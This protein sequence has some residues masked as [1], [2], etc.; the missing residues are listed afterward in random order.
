MYNATDGKT[1]T[2]RMFLRALIRQPKP[3]DESGV[4]LDSRDINL[5]KDSIIQSLQGALDELELAVHDANG[6]AEHIHMYLC[7]LRAQELDDL[8]RAL[9]Y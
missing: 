5:V 7:I 8:T 6:K 1:R 2:R 9:R 3:S 4:E